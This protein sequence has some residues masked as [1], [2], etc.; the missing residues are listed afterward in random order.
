MGLLAPAP[1]PGVETAPLRPIHD[2]D[3]ERWI[4]AH[5][6]LNEL[7]PVVAPINPPAD[8]PDIFPD[9]APELDP[10]ADFDPAEDPGGP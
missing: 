6:Y 9:E 3:V 4:E 2:P 7:A 8:L 5:P 1:A 10:A